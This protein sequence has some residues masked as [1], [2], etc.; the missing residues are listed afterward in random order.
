M[1]SDIRSKVSLK[2]P[3]HF[4]AL[5]GGSGLASFMPG[6]FG[7]LAALPFVAIAGLY[8]P[9]WM[10]VAI[11]FL[12]SVVGVHLCGQT[13]KDM[14]VHDDS[15][16]VWDEFAGMFVAMIAVPISW[17]SLLA[18]FVLFRIFDIA[19][20][21]PIGRLDRKVHGGLGIMV[22][23]ILAGVYALILMHLALHYGWL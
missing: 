18:G 21:W 20:P 23:D 14:G 15:S 13:A 5:G 1:D 6:T 7:T 11:T 9:L 4:L 2:N 22:D 8:T 19:K 3:V 16:I 12:M 10:F 17:Q